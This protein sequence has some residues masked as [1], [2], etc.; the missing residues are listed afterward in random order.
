MIDKRVISV[1]K[2]SLGLYPES[3]SATPLYRNL[4]LAGYDVCLLNSLKETKNFDLII[5]CLDFL[6]GNLG[7][8]FL[9]IRNKPVLLATEEEE[10]VE[11]AAE[12]GVMGIV[13]QHWSPKDLRLVIEFFAI[14]SRYYPRR[15]VVLPDAGPTPVNILL[16]EDDL[17]TAGVVMDSISEF[18][19]VVH[20]SSLNE[21][22]GILSTRKFDLIIL[23]VFLPDGNGLTLLQKIKQNPFFEAIPVLVF[24]VNEDLR[25]KLQAFELGASDYLLK[26][27]HI[28]E[29]KAR[30]KA[31]IGGKQKQEALLCNFKQMSVL[32]EQDGL[33]GLYNHRYFV[34]NL[35][36]RFHLAQEHNVS[37]AVLMMDVDD[38]KLYNDR[39]GHLA[40]DQVLREV[41]NIIRSMVRGDDIPARYGGEEF[42]ALL[43]E[44]NEQQALKVAERI[45][46]AI[47]SY[48]FPQREY[49]PNGKVTISIGVA[50]TPAESPSAMLQKAD[51]ALYR[52]KLAGKN[53]VM[54]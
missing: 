51:E 23:D 8:L 49:Q 15:E 22:E 54:I 39:N 42:V 34:D 40:G 33:T 14:K 31:L 2:V 6:F 52:A 20:T 53:R 45:R 18:G 17:L 3:A 43:W 4:L 37:F 48:P 21:T 46:E 27:F 1:Q 30:V 9:A 41:A 32:A 19:D 28:A 50:V 29:L 44:V 24:S 47:S 16:V 13:G 26:P 38:F 5:V 35:K 10:A 11:Y 12:W 36:H 25:A 7:E